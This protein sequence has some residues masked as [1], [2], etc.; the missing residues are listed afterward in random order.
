MEANTA[1]DLP[2][3][4]REKWLEEIGGMVAVARRSRG[5]TDD[6]LSGRTGI[7]YLDVSLLERG[8][9]CNILLTEMGLIAREVRHELI[10]EPPP[11]REARFSL[12]D[13][14]AY[15]EKLGMAP[16]ITLSPL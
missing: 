12:S 9:G 15:A 11:P 2:A 3:S 8:H 14:A 4:T 1:V 5:I 6:Q 7:V 10:I 16:K 13:F